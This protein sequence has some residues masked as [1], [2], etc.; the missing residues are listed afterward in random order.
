MISPA[1]ILAAIFGAGGTLIAT[2]VTLFNGEGIL[3]TIAVF[4]MSS[5]YSLLL[6]AAAALY[7]WLGPLIALVSI[8]I[9]IDSLLLGGGPHWGHVTFVCDLLELGSG[10]WAITEWLCTVMAIFLWIP[11]NGG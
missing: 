4:F 10:H 1:M 8:A 7:T 6:F 3:V 5:F 9:L 2:V 11:I